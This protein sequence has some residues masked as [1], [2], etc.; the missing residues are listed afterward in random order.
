MK[1]ENHIKR[2]INIGY[3]KPTKK[4]IEFLQKSEGLWTIKTIHLG[5]YGE[6]VESRPYKTFVELKERMHCLRHSFVL[7]YV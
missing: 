3:I 7:R 4:E 6:E 2:K 1:L 5:L